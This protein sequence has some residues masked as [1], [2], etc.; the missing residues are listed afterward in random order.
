MKKNFMMRAASVLL[1]AVMLT[2]CAIS[3]TFAKYVSEATGYDYARVAK[4]GVTITANGDT[5]QTTYDGTVVSSDATDVVAPG[6]TRNFVAMGLTGTPE[7]K[8]EVKYAATLTLAGWTVKDDAEYFPV[9]FT[10]GGETYG[11]TGNTAVALDHGYAGITELKP[12][13]EAAIASYT[14][15]YDANVNLA[16]YAETPVITWT[17]DFSS[18]TDNDAKDTWL[19]DK[20]AAGNAPSINLAITTTVTQID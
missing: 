8:V 16:T 19:G 18:T 3:G 2:T 15:Q 4:W 5:F 20:A 12:A 14:A 11:V 10:I 6:T 13:V 9:Y 7:V 17:W 1:V